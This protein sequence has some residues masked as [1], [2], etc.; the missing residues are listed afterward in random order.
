[1]R[2]SCVGSDIQVEY[3]KMPRPYSDDLRWRMIFQRLFYERSFAEIASQL[4]VCPE[5]VRRTVSTFL[6]TGDVKPCNIGRPT[7]SVSLI[8]HEEYI[9]MDYDIMN[10][11]NTA[12]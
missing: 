5:T 9:I 12:S 2:G 4:F 6:N 11:T 8:P 10:S 3:V 7:G 1:M